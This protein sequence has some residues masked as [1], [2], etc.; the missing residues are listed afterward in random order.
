M[1]HVEVEVGKILQPGENLTITECETLEDATAEFAIVLRNVLSCLLAIL[2]DSFYHARWV[3]KAGIVRVDDALEGRLLHGFGYQFCISQTL[4]I[5]LIGSSFV[6]PF[7][8]T[9]LV[10]PHAA[11]VLQKSGSALNAALVGEV[12]FITLLVDDGVLGLDTHQAPGTRAQI[13]K[14]LVF[15]WYGSYCAGG[16]VTCYGDDRNGIQTRHL[17]HLFGE[18]TD[19]GSWVGHLAKLLSLQSQTLYE[20]VVEIAC[21][22]VENL[23]S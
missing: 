9:A 15:G 17:L 18:C 13:G 16:I 11:D 7:L 3:G 22:R 1:E 6:F 12:E 19:D 8:A 2:L 14:L 20:F 5:L 4:H 10:N 23:G 21:H